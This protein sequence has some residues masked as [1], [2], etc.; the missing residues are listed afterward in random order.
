MP[1][2]PRRCFRMGDG[3]T[4]LEVILTDAKGTAAASAS[5][6]SAGIAWSIG[7]RKRKFFNA[8][9][10]ERN[11]MFLILTLTSWSPPSTSFRR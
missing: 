7:D 1:W 8:L 11:V 4:G 10:V 3:V 6:A 5:R 9:Q 2:R